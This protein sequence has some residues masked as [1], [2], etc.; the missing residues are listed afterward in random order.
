[1]KQ[2]KRTL[3]GKGVFVWNWSKWLRNPDLGIFTD[4]GIAEFDN[5]EDF[6]KW[7]LKKKKIHVEESDFDED[8]EFYF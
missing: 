8:G 5:F 4:C 2:A 6:Q 1:M 7:L 3:N